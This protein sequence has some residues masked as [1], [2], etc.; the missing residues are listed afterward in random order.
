MNTPT[1]IGKKSYKEYE[2]ELKEHKLSKVEKI[3]LNLVGDL[4]KKTDVVSKIMTATNKEWKKAEELSSSTYLDLT[5]V[6][7]EWRSLE[8]K[9]KTFTSKVKAVEK[10]NQNVNSAQDELHRQLTDL[11]NIITEATS[12]T[13]ELGINVN[14]MSGMSEAKDI[15]A[16]S[17]KILDTVRQDGLRSRTMQDMEG[18]LKAILG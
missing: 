17:I 8:T 4:K 11:I 2:K 15:R 12:V 16:M 13:K 3:E 14:D 1:P 10:L 5:D 6:Y 7:D 18:K 9:A